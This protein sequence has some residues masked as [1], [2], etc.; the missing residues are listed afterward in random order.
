MAATRHDTEMWLK[1]AQETGATHMLVMC[2]TFDY[3]YFPV[4]IGGNHPLAIHNQTAKEV[5]DERNGM[6]I[7]IECYSMSLDLEAQLN[8]R[9][10]L[11]YE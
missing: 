2:D 11:N 1:R 3:G 7:V 4:Y 10:A 8:G 9:R 5:A 6:E